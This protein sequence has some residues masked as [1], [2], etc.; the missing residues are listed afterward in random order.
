MAEVALPLQTSLREDKEDDVSFKVINADNLPMTVLGERIFKPFGSD[1][2]KRKPNGIVYPT[3]RIDLSSQQ[4]SQQKHLTK[5]NGHLNVP[6]KLSSHNPN[7]R[8]L[9]ASHGNLNNLSKNK[10]Q[11]EFAKNLD[12]KLKKLQTDRR[13]NDA[14]NAKKPFITTVKKGQFLSPE[15]SPPPNKTSRIE[16]EEGNKKNIP[17]KKQLYAFVSKPMVLSR[18]PPQNVHRSRCE[19]AAIAAG[20]PYTKEFQEMDVTDGH[21]QR[22]K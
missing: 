21:K 10:T 18:S 19:A 13:R 17:I 8:K 16:E 3:R 12:A 15:R 22:K 2:Q 1:N 9:S 11:D 14:F 7:F 6:Q 5:S 20:V 4:V